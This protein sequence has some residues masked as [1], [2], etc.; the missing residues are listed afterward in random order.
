MAGQPR[1]TPA[2]LAALEHLKSK[3]RQILRDRL[4]QF[5]DVREKSRVGS[6]SAN[7]YRLSGP[8]SP[9]GDRRHLRPDRPPAARGRRFEGVRR[10]AGRRY[11]VR[12]QQPLRLSELRRQHRVP[13]NHAPVEARGSN[14]FPRHFPARRLFARSDRRNPASGGYWHWQRPDPSI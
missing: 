3:A 13:R 12:G 11:S 10:A 5:R 8:F 9:R 1:E 2:R 4:R 7:R 6:R 14:P